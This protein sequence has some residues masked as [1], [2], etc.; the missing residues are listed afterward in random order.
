MYSRTPIRRW[1]WALRSRSWWVGVCLCV[2]SRQPLAAWDPSAWNNPHPAIEQ[3]ESIFYSVF[4]ERPKHLDPVSAYNEN[5]ALFTTQIYEPLLQYHYLK[6]PYTLVPLTATAI[7]TPLYFDAIGQRLSADAPDTSIAKVV[8]RIELK[9]GIRYAPHPAF[10]RGTDGKLLSQ[11]LSAADFR[12]RR[13]LADFAQT[14]TRELVAEDYVHEIKRLAHP[15]LHSPIAAFLGRYIVGLDELATQLRT[16][17]TADPQR[18]IDLRGYLLP[19]AKVIDRYTFEI[20]LRERYPQF[21]YWLAMPFFSPVPWEAD[22]FYAQPGMREHNLSLDWYPVG[23]G[24]YLMRENN[25]NRRIVL[26]RNPNFHGENYPATGAPGDRETGLLKDAGRALPFIN[27]IHFML[28]KEDIPEW[29]KFLQGYYDSSA[30][31]ADGFDQAI[32]FGPDGKPEITPAL[33]AKQ[34]QLA[35]ATQAAISYIGFNMLDPVIGGASERARLLRRAISIAIDTEEQISIFGNGRGVAAQGPIPPGIFG[36]RGGR[37]GINSRVYEWRNERAQRKPLA[38]ASALLAQA[39]FRGGIDPA[40]GKPL[41]LFF[42]ATSAGP[43]TKSLFNWYRKQFAKL[44]L[45]LV[46]R[47]TDYNRF[48]EKMNK[49]DAQIFSWGWNADYPDPEN[50]LFLLYGPNG[51]AEHQGENAGNYENPEYDR[52][53]REMRGLANGPQRQALIDRMLEILREDSPWVWGFHPQAYALHHQWVG[54][55]KPNL[56]ARNT[57]KYLTLDPTL[58][59]TLAQRWNAPILWPLAVVV[60]LGIAAVLAACRIQR[61][62]RQASAL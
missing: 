39:G 60:T 53:F 22:L 21:V 55:V 59:A 8:Y 52:L 15:H 54:N 28:E 34:V 13:T 51:K 44:N 42:D 47:S 11:S 43:D 7:P 14:G 2:V 24:P 9:P 4:Q 1:R 58:R 23:T 25:P 61:R 30:I 31:A 6:R 62:R 18:Y 56:M 16:E 5:E 3:R 49:G 33:R 38:A 12:A 27:E 32:R 20:V 29:G 37:A 45:E 35:V 10:A 48:Q 41:V 46:V 36:Y 40:T 19:G 17:Y 26:V 57:L 50:F